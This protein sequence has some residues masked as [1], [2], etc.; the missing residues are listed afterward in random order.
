[1]NFFH[2]ETFSNI[3]TC[4]ISSALYSPQEKNIKVPEAKISEFLDII[5]NDKVSSTTI[6]YELFPETM[7]NIIAYIQFL[8][9][10][11]N[12][13]MGGS[14][15]QSKNVMIELLRNMSLQA[16]NNS[17]LTVELDFID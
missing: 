13:F 10:L 6:L 7:S 16:L 12:I 8:C 17:N 9:A 4:I 3:L 1:M 5:D 14:K 15:K 11:I 2:L